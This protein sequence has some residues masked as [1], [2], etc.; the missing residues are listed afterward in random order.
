MAAGGALSMM[1]IDATGTMVA[2][3]SIQ[4]DLGLGH[5]TQ[6]WV[7]TIYALT[8]AAAIATGGRL[9]DNFGRSRVFSCGVAL[10][11]LGSL[12]C[13]VSPSLPLLLCGRWIEG[14]GNVL[15][16]PAAAL[17]AAETFGPSQRGRAMGLYS[18]LGGLAMMCGP[19]I[20][21]ILVQHA[22]WRAVF[23]VN[24]PL[25]A[26]TLL[27][28]RVARP[29]EP[30]PSAAP[31]NLGHGLLLAA[32]LGAIVL[33]LQQSHDW[34]WTSPLTIGLLASG[35][36]L[37]AGFLVIQWRSSDPL[38]D[39]RLLISR[40]FAG[41]GVVLFCAQFSIIGQSAFAA[42][43]L[44]RIL[45]FT[46][47]QSGLAMLLF[48]TPLMLL[49]PVAGRLYDRYGVKVPAV[50][51]LSMATIGFF[52]ETQALPY[53]AFWPLIPSMMLIGGGMGLAMSQTYT[54]ATALVAAD[55]RGRAYGAL[56]T[57]RQLGGALGMA[58]IGTVVA[59]TERARVIDIA[60]QAVPP[61]TDPAPLEQLMAQAAYG[62]VEAVHALTTTWPSVAHA[63]R[64]SAARSIADGYYVGA[65]AMAG[66]LVLAA[67]LM[68][69]KSAA[70]RESLEPVG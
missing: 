14:L 37:L 46:P 42:A 8:I 36:A 23:F 1:M 66:G 7:I 26:L 6:Q 62:R 56:D 34:G 4:R 45:R 67:I 16:A 57:L 63:L 12:V 53:C 54:D 20:A 35:M 68:W 24:L 55:R 70:A 47:T 40:R 27:T 31:F 19:I 64:V 49:A 28:L 65:T 3:P 41:D 48:L 32:A 44:Q 69:R 33:A 2:L 59:A 17:L 29:S 58:A 43:Y 39:V 30:Q 13:G 61:G 11:G 10:F 51:G 52:I 22:G 15:M 9:G 5:G 50:L 21:G 25:A 38:I 18:A 60:A